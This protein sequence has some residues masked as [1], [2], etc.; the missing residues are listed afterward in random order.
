M[1]KEQFVDFFRDARDSDV[2]VGI[3]DHSKDFGY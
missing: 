3:F 1:T 2:C